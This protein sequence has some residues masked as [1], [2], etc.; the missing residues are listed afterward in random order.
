MHSEVL[1]TGF[2]SGAAEVVLCFLHRF[3]QEFNSRLLSGAFPDYART[4]GIFDMKSP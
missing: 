1:A 4:H 3:E 2:G